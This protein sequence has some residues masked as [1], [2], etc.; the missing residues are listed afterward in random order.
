MIGSRPDADG[1]I[2]SSEIV[3][4][5]GHGPAARP[6]QVDWRV[7]AQNGA[8]KITDV[9]INGLS[10]AVTG[11]SQMQGVAER[12]GGQPQAILAVM[13]QESAN[14]ALR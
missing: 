10:M 11:R 9:I 8:Y 1:A 2:V 7:T 13:R 5:S 12:N 4:E 14:A 3:S 6:V